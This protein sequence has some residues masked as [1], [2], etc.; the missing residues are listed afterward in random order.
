MMMMIMMDHF[1][2]YGTK[3]RKGAAFLGEATLPP[4]GNLFFLPFLFFLFFFI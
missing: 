2:V 4:T 1:N 3:K